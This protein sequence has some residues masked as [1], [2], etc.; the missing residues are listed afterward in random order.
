MSESAVKRLTSAGLAALVRLAADDAVSVRKAA[1]ACIQA[2][3][4]SDVSSDTAQR[5]WLDTVLP[6]VSDS[7]ATAEIKAIECVNT[8]LFQ[9]IA[10][11]KQPVE[12]SNSVLGSAW[13]CLQFVANDS[14]L[15]AC[16]RKCIRKLTTAGQLDSKRLFKSLQ[17]AVQY[18]DE[19]IGLGYAEAGNALRR[20]YLHSMA[21]A[22]FRIHTCACVDVAVLCVR[23]CCSAWLLLC[24]LVTAECS[25]R[26]KTVKLNTAFVLSAWTAMSAVAC[27]NPS[28]DGKVCI[29][30]ARVPTA[31]LLMC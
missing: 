28:D 8:V 21:F 27:S 30:N 17:S 29:W 14:D 16:V 12:H 5:L 15:E 6:M 26:S 23:A 13:R 7:E 11:W 22:S 20:R 3:Y 18:G 1:M 9:P 31:A 25:G 10:Q 4:D 2:V 19:L 24:E